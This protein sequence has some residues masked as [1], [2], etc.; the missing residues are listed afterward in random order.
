MRFLSGFLLIV[1]ASS[2]VFAM[3]L[4][5]LNSASK[6]DLMQIN[7]VGEVKAAAIIKERRRGKFKSYDDLAQRVDGIGEQTAHNIKADIKNS[8][9]VKKVTKKRR[10]S[11]KKAHSDKKKSLKSKTRNTMED[12]KESLKKKSRKKR[13]RKEKSK[14]SKSK[15]SKSKKS[16]TKKSRSKSKSSK[17][18]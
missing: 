9:A 11:T 16:K 18:S 5:R 7:G 3:S 4:S 2:V 10:K 12:K 6:D 1:F 13:D 15:K 17:E 14:K 8:E